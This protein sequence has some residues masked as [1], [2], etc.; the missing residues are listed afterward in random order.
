MSNY[1]LLQFAIRR[2]V[3][4]TLCVLTARSLGVDNIHRLGSVSSHWR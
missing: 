3:L 4:T 2:A 1:S